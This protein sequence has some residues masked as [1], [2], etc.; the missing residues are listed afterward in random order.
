M[1]PAELESASTTRL[2]RNS[3]CAPTGYLPGFSPSRPF[4]A[5]S[6]ARR[7]RGASLL[8]AHT[9]LQLPSPPLPNLT[10]CR[11]RSPSPS[12]ASSRTAS[13][14]VLAPVSPVFVTRESA[15]AALHVF[16]G[17]TRA[18]P[19]LMRPPSR[20]T[21]RASRRPS[22]ATSRPS[23]SSLRS[24]ARPSVRTV[25]VS[26]RSSSNRSLSSTPSAARALFQ[27]V[28]Q[29]DPARIAAWGGLLIGGSL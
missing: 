3:P 2:A 21:C 22:C 16:C 13:R 15:S 1:R 25:R 28:R 26:R 8:A 29:L 4:R 11:S 27:V 24:S 12:L 6:P 20:S 10:P 7:P 5:P 17:L 23:A 18:R 14:S 9:S 19:S